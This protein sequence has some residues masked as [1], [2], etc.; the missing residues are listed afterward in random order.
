[1]ANKTQTKKQQDTYFEEPRKNEKKTKKRRKETE[2]DRSASRSK[3]GTDRCDRTRRGRQRP[4]R[5]YHRR[6]GS[7]TRTDFPVGT[8]RGTHTPMSPSRG[9][10]INAPVHRSVHATVIVT[11]DHV[12]QGQVAALRARSPSR[13]HDS[14]ENHRALSTAVCAGIHVPRI[15]LAATDCIPNGKTTAVDIYTAVQ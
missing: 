7:G 6:T 15:T 2:T 4:A 13:R 5:R 9:G 10:R 1:M 3:L 12:Y 8:R 11:P 14:S